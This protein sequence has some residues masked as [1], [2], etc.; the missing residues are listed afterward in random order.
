[1]R[2]RR[3]LLLLS[4]LLLLGLGLVGIRML[5]QPERVSQFLITQAQQATGLELQLAE[6]AKVGFWPDLHV[7]LDGLSAHAPGA[8]KPLLHVQRVEAALPW[9]SLRGDSITLRGLRL[10]APQLDL[11]ATVAFLS[12]DQANTPRRSGR[13][14]LPQLDAPFAVE[15]G[16]IH[17]DDWQVQALEL[18]LP[19]LHEGR[20]MTLQAN[21]RLLIDSRNLPFAFVLQ[22]TPHSRPD[23]LHLDP[24]QLDLRSDLLPGGNW[25]LHGHLHWQP[26]GRLD[27]ALKSELARWPQNWP[28]LPLAAQDAAGPLQLQLSYQG[29]STLA[30]PLQLQLAL[31]PLQ[32]R[33]RLVLNELLL[34][35]ENPVALPPLQLEL[36]SPRLQY[37]DVLARG[38]RM[39][40]A[41]K[42]AEKAA[43]KTASEA[44][45]AASGTANPAPSQAD[46]QPAP[47]TPARADT[48]P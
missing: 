30:D 5:L 25:P 47:N 27:T 16:Q 46:P 44:R 2:K 24:L 48:P 10:L 32:A 1:M 22:T 29:D 9:A 33:T 41:D 34:W 20:P 7:Q 19:S 39:R 13:I 42:A 45:D 26:E 18:H 37:A 38:I 8:E 21:G 36:E 14:M 28:A 17:G 6:P 4:P 40:M 43:E 11:P 31:G 23:A 3:W 35:L 15:D 12:P